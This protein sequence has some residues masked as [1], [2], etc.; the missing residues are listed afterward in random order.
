M[1]EGEF[2]VVSRRHYN[3]KE[4]VKLTRNTNTGAAPDRK[5]WDSTNR[6]DRFNWYRRS[7]PDQYSGEGRGT[8]KGKGSGGKGSGSGLSQYGGKGRG[9]GR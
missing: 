1:S 2:V 3:G 7:G 8:G 4:F 5:F 9:G 6:Y